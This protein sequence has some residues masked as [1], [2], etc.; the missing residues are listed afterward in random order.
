M[1]LKNKFLISSL[2]VLIAIFTFIPLLGKVHLFDWD[3]INF[4]ESA[5]EMIYSGN[6]SRVQINYKP[7][8]EK[9]PLFFWMQAVAMNVFGINE[10][11]ARFPNAICGVLSLLFVFYI[12]QKKYDLKF[13][14]IWFLSYYGSILPSLYFRTGIID[15]FFNLFIYIGIY[16]LYIGHS[17]ISVNSFL[18]SGV[19]TGIAVLTKGP[20]AGLII[21]LCLIMYYLLGRLKNIPPIRHIIIFYITSISISLIWFGF[22][23]FK[24]GTWFITEFIQ[25]HIELF[26]TSQAGHG[27]PFYYHPI[28]LLMGCYPASIFAVYYLVNTN[29]IKQ[30]FSDEFIKWQYILFFVVLIL[31]SIVKTKIL[32]YSSLCYF[33]LT[34][35]AAYS[36]HKQ[37]TSS[38]RYSKFILSLLFFIGFVYSL[39][40]GFLPYVTSN[41]ELFSQF[42]EDI[43]IKSVYSQI[44][45]W[46]KY[47]FG[48]GF[49]Y[50]SVIIT[51]IYYLY[52]KKTIL[53]SSILFSGT[54]LLLILIQILIIPKLE[55]VL[56]AGP[57]SFYQ[58]LKDKDC[59]I[60][61]LGFK[62]FAYLFY[63]DK[64][65][66]KSVE[67][68]NKQWLLFGQ[69][70]KPAYFV[71]KIG[72]ADELILIKDLIKI[73]EENGFIYYLRMPI[74]NHDK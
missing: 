31:F 27:Q 43:Y 6:F 66:Y 35:F 12:G 44:I 55:K 40:L 39:F 52:N 3:E 1:I 32:H 20:V 64:K 28:V 4:A 51:S 24:N 9:P 73:K 7:F 18:I 22:E 26:S 14:L 54:S 30:L 59:Y 60:E 15:P 37:A 50:I 74:N 16:F 69:I 41:K 25:Y 56:Q 17:T 11:A 65:P 34:F 36:I 47:E 67:T 21:T 49:F 71:S 48:I 70:D 5:R 42:I 63:S 68:T 45:D 61:V 53:G 13:G 23:T 33:P 10:F 29:L 58:S 57:I 46:G 62:S 2:I 38:V 72:K 19:W 8:W